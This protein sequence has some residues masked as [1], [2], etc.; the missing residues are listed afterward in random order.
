MKIS[1]FCAKIEAALATRQPGAE[2]YDIISQSLR[3]VFRLQPDEVAILLADVEQDVLRFEWPAKLQKSGTVPLSSRD[4]LA[5]RTWREKKIQLNN[6]F[7]A[8]YHAAIFEHVKLDPTAAS[9]PL[10]IQKIISAPIP[11]ESGD[12]PKGVLQISRKGQEAA[13]V[14]DFSAADA[15][16][17]EEMLKSLAKYL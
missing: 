2:R 15:A 10:P 11:T 13:D 3:Q 12:V 6:R 17:L 7:A 9:R 14:A 16:T 8:T 1:D 5:A 4:S